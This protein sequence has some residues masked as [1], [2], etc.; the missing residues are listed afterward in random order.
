MRVV[1]ARSLAA[2]VPGEDQAFATFLGGRPYRASANDPV[3]ARLLTRVVTLGGTLRGHR[4]TAETSAGSVRYVVTPV[5]VDGRVRGGFAAARFL[6]GDQLRIA[7]TAQVAAGVSII[8]LTFVTLLAYLLAG[9]VLAP[10]RR[11]TETTRALGESDLSSRVEV[12]GDD[13][14]AELG[15]TFNGMLDRLEGAFSNQKELLRDAAHELQRPI[16][17]IRGHLELMGDD[18][19]DRQETVEL[20]SEELD[21]MGL[22]V[23]DL[24]L[25]AET[26]HGD[27]LEMDELDLETFTEELL[28]RVRGLAD[29]DWALVATGGAELV[30]DRRRVA[31]AVM[32]LARNAV[33]ATLPGDRIELGSACDAGEA[34]LWIA[35]AADT[36]DGA[37]DADSPAGD[38]EPRAGAAGLGLSIARTIA[39][40][41]GGRLE[42]D[43][44]PEGAVTFTC[45]IPTVS[46][47]RAVPA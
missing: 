3:Q 32:N 47:P 37:L 11:V 46:S 5:R 43:T 24:L 20:V 27:F 6:R 39:E 33:A 25:L 29:R 41:H 13:E 1:L 28:A 9:R 17:T 45:V 31:Q 19:D 38:D 34:R 44:G 14:V 12:R 10:L 22:F 36:A 15:R 42:V 26:E 4:A 16:A 2:N 8:L 35:S 30:A 40:G 18:P 7:E 23:D 21:R